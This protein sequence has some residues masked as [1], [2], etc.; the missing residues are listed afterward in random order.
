VHLAGILASSQT[1]TKDM[2]LK[3]SLIKQIMADCLTLNIYLRQQ[4]LYPYIV[5][6]ALSSN[7][8]QAAFTFTV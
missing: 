1:A 8:T 6:I 4:G 7:S 3:E 5:S 2:V